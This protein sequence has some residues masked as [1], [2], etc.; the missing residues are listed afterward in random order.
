MHLSKH[1]I[2][3]RFYSDEGRQ[4]LDEKAMAS[5]VLYGERAIKFNS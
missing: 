1:G 2:I 4:F 3:S 5:G